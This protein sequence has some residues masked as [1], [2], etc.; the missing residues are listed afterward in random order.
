[1][2]T[3][4]ITPDVDPLFIEAEQTSADF[5]LFP[6]KDPVPLSENLQ[7]L[8]DERRIQSRLKTIQK[9]TVDEYIE[10]TVL[11][12]QHGKRPGLHGKSRPR[13]ACP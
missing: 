3:A 1:M 13:G 4:P 7:G 10:Q 11:P 6:D 9:L 5:S 2:A 8:V 12:A